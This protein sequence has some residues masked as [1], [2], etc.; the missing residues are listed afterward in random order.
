MDPF[1]DLIRLLQPQATLWTR[2]EA[3]GR[4]GLAFR[5]RNDLLFCRVERGACQLTR[6]GLEPLPLRTN[7]F[8]LVRTSTP[9]S[10]VSEADVE[11]TDSEAVIAGAG[12]VVVL[13]EDNLPGTVLRG[14]RF[15]FNTA[16]EQ[17]LTGLLPQVVHV[18][19]EANASERV[20]T[21]LAMNE[22][23]SRVGDPGS[24]F[25]VAR[26]MELVLVEILR[27]PVFGPDNPQACLLTGLADPVAAKALTAMHRD[28]ARRWTTQTLARVCGTSRSSLAA[29]F[30]RVVGVGPME[31]LQQWRIALAKDHLRRG[32]RSIA[33][34]ALAIG[35]KSGSAFSTAFKRGVGRS[36]RQFSESKLSLR[37]FDGVG[38]IGSYSEVAL[39][40][41]IRPDVLK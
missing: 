32:T 40:E 34:I 10:L 30:T 1:L 38:Q 17:L 7:D 20:R 27:S 18:A 36:P 4:W 26:L 37:Q 31:Y 13:G 33:E 39:P 9:F 3:S 8:V 24:D 14:G 11:P 23:E 21:L 19:A 41:A 15:V 5:Q 35:F 29:R 6:L 22:A 12:S 16:N 28:V 2:V 25:V